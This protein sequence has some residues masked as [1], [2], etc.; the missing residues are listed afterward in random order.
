MSPQEPITNE[1]PTNLPT[2]TVITPQKDQPTPPNPPTTKQPA[3]ISTQPQQ[4]T[5]SGRTLTRQ[6]P[7]NHIE[8]TSTPPNCLPD[9]S[10]THQSTT[11]SSV[12]TTLQTLRPGRKPLRHSPDI[13]LETS[14]GDSIHHQDPGTIRI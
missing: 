13:N 12:Q 7:D 14:Y 11:Y 1:S 5:R 3:T 2:A 4:S 6:Y 8:T 10:T 9:S